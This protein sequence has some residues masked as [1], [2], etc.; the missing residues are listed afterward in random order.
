[1]FSPAIGDSSSAH[2]EYMLPKLELWRIAHLLIF[3]QGELYELL[4][5]YMTDE[6][7]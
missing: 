1:M 3:S 2:T 7:Q 5:R 6:L 4:Q